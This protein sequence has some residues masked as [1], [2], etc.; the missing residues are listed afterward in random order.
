M[1][2]NRLTGVEALPNAH[3]SKDDKSPSCVGVEPNAPPEKDIY[4]VSV[5]YTPDSEKKWHVLRITYHRERKAFDYLVSMGLQ[6][7]MPMR[8]TIRKEN[9]RQRRIV[10]PLISGILFVYAKPET[11]DLHIKGNASV[12]F[13]TYYYNHFHTQPNGKNPPLVVPYADMMNF[14]RVTN[15]GNEHVRTVLP[16]QCHWRGGE[17]VRI[18][19]GAFTGVEGRVARI[20]GQQRVVVEV[21]GV[22]LVST[23][24]IPSA[25]LRAIE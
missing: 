4:G 12:S 8:H 14:I 22:C 9:G 3:S 11:I 23:A 2:V 21:E 18:I 24:Y 5:E 1:A 7:Y 25:F 15:I 20:A 13:I 6:V 19:E 16:H 10:T 17:R